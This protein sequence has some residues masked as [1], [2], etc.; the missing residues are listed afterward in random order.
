[1]MQVKEMVHPDPIGADYE[2][3]FAGANF[4]TEVVSGALV[5]VSGCHFKAL[6]TLKVSGDPLEAPLKSPDLYGCHFKALA[7]L[8]VSGDPLKAPLKSPDLY[9]PAADN[10]CERSGHNL[11]K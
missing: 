9:L 2:Q 10:F 4:N 11:M 6:A 5:E 8:K 3:A 7:T 1:M